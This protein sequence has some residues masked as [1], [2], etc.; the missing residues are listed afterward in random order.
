MQIFFYKWR[1]CTRILG[2]HFILNQTGYQNILIYELKDKISL[3]F[4]WCWL[5]RWKTSA[6]VQEHQWS[7]HS[8][9]PWTLWMVSSTSYRSTTLIS[10]KLS[11]TTETY[12]I[13]S[14]TPSKW[15]I[16]FWDALRWCEG[17]IRFFSLVRFEVHEILVNSFFLKRAIY[18][19]CS[20]FWHC[21]SILLFKVHQYFWV[22]SRF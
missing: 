4:N 12:I 16:H 18:I 14:P 7:T 11:T 20:S 17:T 15:W 2:R 13:Y 3:T 10:P 6:A 21:F 5:S 9:S 22:R 19:C 8:K 1:W